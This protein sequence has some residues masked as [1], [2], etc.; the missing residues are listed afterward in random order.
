MHR[1]R[2]FAVLVVSMFIGCVQAHALPAFMMR[3][4]Q[5]PFSR[6]ELR[7]EC[8]TCHI[9]PNGGGPR[10]AFGSAFE[11]NDHVVTAQLRQSWPDHFLPS[12]TVNAAAESAEIIVTFM[13]D[14][15]DVIVEIAGEQFRLNTHEAKL[16]K[17][18]KYSSI[19]A[20]TV[21]PV[22]PAQEPK[23]PLRNQP[24]F[25]HYLVNLPTSLPY[26]AGVLSMRFNHRFSQPVLG[27]DNRC[28]GIGDLWGLDSFSNSSIGISYGI[29]PYAAVTFYRSPVLKTIEMGG[30]VQAL[31]QQ[32]GS[33]ISAALRMSAEGRNNFKDD[34]TANLVFALSRGISNVAELFVVPMMSFNANPS[35]FAAGPG[36]PIGGLRR[37]LGAVGL[38]ASVRFRPRAAFV[39]E[40]MPRVGGYRPTN[41]RNSYS[42]GIQRSTNGHV[43]ELT[44]SN[45]ITTTTSQWVSTG[46]SQF[47]LGFNLYRRLRGVEF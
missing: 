18:D 15:T 37:N 39:A 3:F 22:S 43:F 42:F 36:I 13:A 30:V 41:S 14:G 24:T 2:R 12:V 47:S 7:N 17:T 33:P 16:E 45:T 11:K 34:Y 21:S 35:P 9:N 40:W 28:A 29:T 6:P 23:L 31:R 8:S 10:N 38:G 46:T 44:L 4:S 5:D 27:C 19:A 32:A 26:T 25:D 20:Q 1:S